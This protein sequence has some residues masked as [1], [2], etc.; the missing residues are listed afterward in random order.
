M[1]VLG[2]VIRRGKIFDCLALSAISTFEIVAKLEAELGLRLGGESDK[3]EKKKQIH[4]RKRF[5]GRGS[6]LSTF[7]YSRR[8]R[9]EGF[10]LVHILGIAWNRRSR[11]CISAGNCASIGSRKTLGS[12]WVRPWYEADAAQ[13]SDETGWSQMQE[14][15]RQFSV[16][17][18]VGVKNCV[19]FYRTHLSWKH[20]HRKADGREMV[21]VIK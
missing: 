6:T 13:N 15:K 7:R 8:R 19:S 17:H 4:A 11:R 12:N 1:F 16:E 9:N 20:R 10:E 2:G 5:H 18:G 21:I 14:E 3:K